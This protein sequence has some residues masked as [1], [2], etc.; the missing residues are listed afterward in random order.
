MQDTGNQFYQPENGAWRNRRVIALAT[1]LGTLALA[2][3]MTLNAGTVSSNDGSHYALTLA[4]SESR[5]NID[6]FEH[7]TRGVDLAKY[8][9]R[10]YADRPPGT[11]FV[12]LPLVVFGKKLGVK[13]R[14]LEKLATSA[15]ALYGASAVVLLF[16]LLIRMNYS[17][18]ASLFSAGCF[19]FGTHHRSYSTVLFH[20]S[21]SALWVLIIFWL[22]PTILKNPRHKRINFVFGFLMGFLVLVE[23]AGLVISATLLA[24]L[25]F[26]MRNNRTLHAPSIVSMTIGGIAGITPLLVYN[27]LCFDNPFVLAY[28]YHARFENVRTM[29]SHA[30]GSMVDGMVGLLVGVPQSVLIWSPIVAW[31][32]VWLLLKLKQKE[33]VKRTILYWVPCVTYVLALSNIVEWHGGAHDSR[34]LSPI[35]PFF[36]IPIAAAVDT[37]STPFRS[38]WWLV[39]LSVS[40]ALS[41][42]LQGVKHHVFWARDGSIWLEKTK[43][44]LVGTENFGEIASDFIG[45][46]YPGW[47]MGLTCLVIG[48]GASIIVGWSEFGNCSTP[49]SGD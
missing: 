43:Q 7:H 44:V 21:L 47:L 38:R 26:I 9:G 2:Q 35:L 30:S 32:Y 34:Y 39:A 23:F 22:V 37:L 41:C 36:F 25:F 8:N 46:A 31:T 19:A 6:G 14:S 48:G 40:A 4:F 28:T 24:I 20:H 29:S 1:A 42:A 18:F 45:W 27:W 10:Y 3:S 49:S 33:T 5:V 12:T 16:L 15:S 11:A 17:H 13:A